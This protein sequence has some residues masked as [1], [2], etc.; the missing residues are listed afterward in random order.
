MIGEWPLRKLVPAAALVAALGSWT[1]VGCSTSSESSSSRSA[2]PPVEAV[3]DNPHG[4]NV[5]LPNGTAARL[6]D[7]VRVAAVCID[8]P[9]LDLQVAVQSGSNNG[10]VAMG[11]RPTD[12]RPEPH[13]SFG[14]LNDCTP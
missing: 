12:L 9:N 14:L 4:V 8:G 11:V 5:L 6:R 10:D 2:V 3:V 1:L 7:G 13:R